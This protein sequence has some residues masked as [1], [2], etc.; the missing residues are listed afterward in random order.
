MATVKITKFTNVTVQ[1]FTMIINCDENIVE[2]QL[3]INDKITRK[4]VTEP[5]KEIKQTIQAELEECKCQVVAKTEKGKVIT[6]IPR[7]ISTIP[8]DIQLHAEPILSRPGYAEVTI[9]TNK[10]SKVLLKVNN[11]NYYKKYHGENDDYKFSIGKLDN[12]GKPYDNG[13]TITKIIKVPEN[14]YVKISVN[15]F[16]YFEGQEQNGLAAYTHTFISTCIPSITFD[17]IKFSR[18]GTSFKGC[19][20]VN[21]KNINKLKLKDEQASFVYTNKIGKE[22]EIKPKSS[23]VS[24]TDKYIR[25][26]K[27]NGVPY[28]LVGYVKASAT[29]VDSGL[30]VDAAQNFKTHGNITIKE[31]NNLRTVFPYIAVKDVEEKIEF[32]EAKVFIRKDNRWKAIE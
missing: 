27:F 5:I 25:V 31:N 3:I 10:Y 7:T 20:E 17:E 30:T 13:G 12:A 8:V 9:A 28:D 32:K 15:V 19:L 21:V 14:E 16:P 4:I 24:S 18:E 29:S 22:I 26:Y 6:S 1:Y 23:K 2:W 11:E